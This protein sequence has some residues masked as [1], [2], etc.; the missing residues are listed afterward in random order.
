[1]RC[2]VQRVIVKVMF[3]FGSLYTLS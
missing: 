3:K 1:M 2:S